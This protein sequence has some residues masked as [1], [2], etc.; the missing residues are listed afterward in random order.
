VTVLVKNKHLYLEI[1]LPIYINKYIYVDILLLSLVLVFI[2][3]LKNTCYISF[4]HIIIY[5]SAGLQRE[6]D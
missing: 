5:K 6:H 4:I 3:P 1:G 2:V